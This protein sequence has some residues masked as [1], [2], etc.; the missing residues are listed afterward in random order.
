MEFI[1]NNFDL[2]D[3]KRF[4]K[5]NFDGYDYYFYASFLLK[6]DYSSRKEFIRELKG[7][8]IEELFSSDKLLFVHNAINEFQT[9][10]GFNNYDMIIYPDISYNYLVR[11]CIDL[12]NKWLKIKN[13]NTKLFEI[14][15]TDP[16]LIYIENDEQNKNIEKAEKYLT[17][18]HNL[19]YFSI[20]KNGHSYRRYVRN[21]LETSNLEFVIKLKQADENTKILIF[22]D[23]NSTGSTLR[24]IFRVLKAINDKLEY[25]IY[26][27]IGKRNETIMD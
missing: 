21:F 10:I 25:N 6:M 26:T 1:M 14:T 12:I 27:I 2:F 19:D 15:K 8:S 24:E 17:D 9:K 22:D 18:I 7:T 16:K 3:E 13:A 4:I 23:I 5:E 11:Y 20:A